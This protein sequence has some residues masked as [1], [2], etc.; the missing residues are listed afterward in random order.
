[1]GLV[2]CNRIKFHSHNLKVITRDLNFNSR[3]RFYSGS[4][5]VTTRF[6]SKNL[7]TFKLCHHCTSHTCDTGSLVTNCALSKSHVGATPRGTVPHFWVSKW[8]TLYWSPNC[9]DPLAL[10]QMHKFWYGF[11][12]FSLGVMPGPQFTL[13]MPNCPWTWSLIH[14]VTVT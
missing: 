1:M 3:Q 7:A 9:W 13:P 11:S 10:L 5:S 4:G 12:K 6:L 8:P 14:R 2:T